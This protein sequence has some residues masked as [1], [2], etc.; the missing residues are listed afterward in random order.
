MAVLGEVTPVGRCEAG[1]LAP[2]AAVLGPEHTPP[3]H[4]APCPQLGLPPASPPHGEPR[5]G[6]E[7]GRA[8]FVFPLGGRE[9]KRGLDFML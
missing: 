6:P 8:A 2:S 1:D 5:G 4:P 7:A 3:T 9:E